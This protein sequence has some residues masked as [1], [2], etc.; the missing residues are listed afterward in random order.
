MLT[1]AEIIALE[2]EVCRLRDRIAACDGACDSKDRDY[3]G[4]LHINALALGRAIRAFA[5]RL[6]RQHGFH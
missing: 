4:T 2:D 1:R 3:M 5:I 6:E